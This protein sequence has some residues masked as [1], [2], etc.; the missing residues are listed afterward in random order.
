MNSIEDPT[1]NPNIVPLRISQHLKDLIDAANDTIREHYDTL[2]EQILE[3]YKTAKLEGFTPFQ[4]RLLIKDRVVDVSDRYVRSVL[5]AEARDQS[6]KNLYIKHDAEDVPHHSLNNSG[7]SEG[8]EQE[9]PE[10]ESLH[11]L[12]E[13][14]QELEPDD[15]KK[16][17]DRVLDPYEINTL[18]SDLERARKIIREQT[19]QIQRLSIK[20][21]KTFGHKF[22]YNTDLQYP[23]GTFIPIIITSFPDKERAYAIFDEKRAGGT[24]E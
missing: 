21:V 17:E 11:D 7:K 6:K 14:T 5:P 15:P 10:Q 13:P 2:K 1:Q 12:P 8:E 4:A 9:V 24:Q 19:E 16:S 18:K 22:N 20:Q 23:K 3:I